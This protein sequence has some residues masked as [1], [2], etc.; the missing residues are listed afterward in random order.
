M[1][2][3]SVGNFGRGWDGSI[4]DEEHIA[5][6]LESLGHTV[7]RIQREST[8]EAK[9]K[10]PAADFALVAQWDGYGNDLIDRLRF[11]VPKVIYWAFDYQA[12]G[13]LWHEQLIKHCDLYLSKRL[14][15]SRFGHWN[16]LSQDFAPEFLHRKTGYSEKDIDILF[17]GSYLPWAEERNK[18]LKAIDDNFDL[19]IHSVTPDGWKDA[20]FKIVN[21]PVMDEGLIDLVDRAKINISIDHTLEAGYW[22]DRTAQIMACG[23]FTLMRYI[24]MAEV[25]FQSGVQFF[26]NPGDALR[27]IDEFLERDGDCQQAAQEG[28]DYAQEFLG[29]E[30]RVNDLLAI[31]KEIL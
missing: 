15:D 1:N 10:F 9:W 28:Y 22:S 14:A 27:L 20:G 29:V 30:S 21:G 16:W 11:F 2:I 8:L 5:A 24:P 18:T 13:Q 31:V 26:Y 25:R 17:T 12:D 23:G 19:T 6:A 4:C 3:L 7:S